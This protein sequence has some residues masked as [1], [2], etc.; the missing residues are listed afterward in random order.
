MTLEV[1]QVVLLERA[2]DDNKDEYDRVDITKRVWVC[3][4]RDASPIG[5]KIKLNARD[6]YFKTIGPII[7]HWDKIYVKLKDRKNNIFSTVVHVNTI[8]PKDNTSYGEVLELVCPH[9]SSNLLKIKIPLSARRDSG[10]NTLHDILKIINTN[11]GAEYPTIHLDNFGNDGKIRNSLND[12]VTNDYLIEMVPA[13]IAINDILI[14]EAMP[15]TTG[16]SLLFY[17]F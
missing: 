16:G 6:G 11:K 5:C 3:D 15:Q 12:N 1:L 2:L 10:K 14:K 8:H 13:G 4:V 17:F 9:E 7:T